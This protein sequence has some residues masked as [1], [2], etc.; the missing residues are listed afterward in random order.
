VVR[1]LLGNGAAEE[2]ERLEHSLAAFASSG[3]LQAAGR[4]RELSARALQQLGDEMLA[5]VFTQLRGRREGEHLVRGQPSGHELSGTSREYRFGDPLT[6]DLSRTVLD[7]VRRGAGVPVRLEPNDFAIF[8]REESA[9]AATVLLI[10]LSRSMGERGYL[11]AAKKLALALSTLIRNRFPRDR[12]LLAAFSES[13][14]TLQP[15]D[16]PRLAWD[17][18]SFGTNIQEA[19]RLGRALLAGH[20]G[21]QRTL[22]LITDGEPTAHR[23]EAGQVRFNHPPTEATLAATYAE[24]ERARR[25][26]LTLCVCV[27]S[28]ERQVVRFADELARRAAGELIVTTPDDLGPTLVL[29]YGRSRA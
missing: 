10:D 22:L 21:M 18:F 28:S 15:A 19:L 20:R 9:R 14:R 13:A 3:Y 29:R 11:L 2:L 6:L 23:D 7:A 5:A 26:G 12:L 25:D 17:R 4:R 24:A 1:A 16:L 27:L 8:E